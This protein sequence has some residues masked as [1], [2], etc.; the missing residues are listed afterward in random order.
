LTGILI[1]PTTRTTKTIPY[2]RNCVIKVLFQQHI[3][4]NIN[5]FRNID[6]NYYSD[7]ERSKIDGNDNDT[8]TT[9]TI[10]STSTSN[11]TTN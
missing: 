2:P 10:V 6:R 1:T 9:T 11:N 4:T 8:T 7:N 3:D 5:I